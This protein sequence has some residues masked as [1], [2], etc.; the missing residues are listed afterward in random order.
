MADTSKLITNNIKISG[1][2]SQSSVYGVTIFFTVVSCLVVLARLL[3]RMLIVRQP[4]AD[5]AFIS[6]A[7]V[8]A[9]AQ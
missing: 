5:D 9:I 6:A 7:C 4:G 8:R 2:A 1:H 3:T